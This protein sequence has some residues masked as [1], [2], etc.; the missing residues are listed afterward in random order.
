VDKVTE[1]MRVRRGELKPAPALLSPGRAPFVVGLCGTMERPRL[2]LDL[3]ALLRAEMERE[4]KRT[5]GTA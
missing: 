1:V 4:A 3:K 5:G 2:M